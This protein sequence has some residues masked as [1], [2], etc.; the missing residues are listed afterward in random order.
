MDATLRPDGR[1][2][3]GLLSRRAGTEGSARHGSNG[4]YR[5]PFKSCPMAAMRNCPETASP[6]TESD[7]ARSYGCA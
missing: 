7:C 4:E 5:R 2:G 1:P 6:I 3:T